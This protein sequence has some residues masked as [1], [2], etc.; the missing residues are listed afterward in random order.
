MDESKNDDEQCRIKG[1]GKASP[2]RL[3]DRIDPRITKKAWYVHENKNRMMGCKVIA[4]CLVGFVP[5]LHQQQIRE[6]VVVVVC[7][8]FKNRN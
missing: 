6:N 7:L 1:V 3:I 4:L 5:A 2:I 8:S